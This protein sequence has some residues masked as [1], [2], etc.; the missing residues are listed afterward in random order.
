M[1]RTDTYPLNRDLT[2]R[3]RTGQPVPVHGNTLTLI[4]PENSE[5]ITAETSEGRVGVECRLNLQIS[6]TLYHRI[7]TEALFNLDPNLRGSFSKGE[8]LPESD[9]HLEVT[10]QPNVLPQLL[11]HAQTAETAVKYLTNLSLQPA[12]AEITPA[13]PETESLFNTENWICLSVKQIQD[14]GET[15]YN[16]FWQYVSPTRL[17]HP[18]DFGEQIVDGFVNFMKDELQDNIVTAAQDATTELLQGFTSLVSEL[19]HWADATLSEDAQETATHPSILNTAI[20]FFVIEEWPFVQV[21]KEP[22]LRLSFRGDHGQW[23]C[24]ATARE[25]ASQFVF[26]S[27]CPILVP[28]AKQ[29][30]IAE[31]IAR[32]NYGIVVGN[33]E[34]DFSDGEIR[35]KTSI[36]VGDD[37]LTVALVKHLVYTNVMTMD[38]YLPAILAVIEG[39]LPPAE[40]IAQV[41]SNQSGFAVS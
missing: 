22:T 21:Q 17:K 34:M 36:D 24:Y 37:R 35:Y 3:D 9:L 10:L 39:D 28:T 31:F 2:F 25:E 38:Y 15:G 13:T 26:Y 12:E 16:T 7:D 32:A 6:P 8:F 41:E 40:A 18:G 5:A 29:L 11:S 4:Q 27:I 14:A 33:F 30:E 1:M 20:Q 23:I 19:E